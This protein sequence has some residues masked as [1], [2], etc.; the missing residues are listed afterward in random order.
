VSGF[1]EFQYLSIYEPIDR[2]T[3]TRKSGKMGD[4][5]DDKGSPAVM[6]RTPRMLHESSFA[7][8]AFTSSRSQRR[9]P[10]FIASSLD[11]KFSA[12][13]ATV[14]P[15]AVTT[16]PGRNKKNNDKQQ[17][18]QLEREKQY[19][20]QRQYRSG[21]PTR[22][23]GNFGPPPHSVK[24]L[25]DLENMSEEQIYKLFMDDPDLHQEFIKATEKGG[26]NENTVPSTMPT[27]AKKARRSA[28][29]PSN[30]SKSKRSSTKPKNL[31]S[32]DVDREVPYFQW[33]FLFILIC[34]A[35]YKIYK[36]CSIPSSTKASKKVVGRKQKKKKVEKLGNKISTKTIVVEVKVKPNLPLDDKKGA[37]K[38]LSSK[39]KRR[40]KAPKARPT[41]SASAIVEEKEND[42]AQM[43]DQHHELDMDSED[44]S[45]GNHGSQT[46]KVD[47]VFQMEAALASSPSTN[48]SDEAWQTVTK[49]SKG[50]TKSKTTI[51]PSLIKETNVLDQPIAESMGDWDVVS[52]PKKEV[53]ENVGEQ[54]VEQSVKPSAEPP[55]EPPVEPSVEEPE[56]I[57]KK[58]K[59][60]KKKTGNDNSTNE[61]KKN[62]VVK[63]IET[64]KSEAGHA[65]EANVIVSEVKHLEKPDID[66]TEKSETTTVDDA[67]LALQLHEKEVNFAMST[68]GNPQEEVWEEVT[69]K[70]KA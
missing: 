14:A 56:F 42:P 26:Y 55:V 10:G 52:E 19:Q 13:G 69:K 53:V 3:I 20:Q 61:E 49:S 65:V 4:Q 33:L 16:K 54:S 45:S 64:M 18:E 58:K 70:K 32:K 11:F 44:G 25:E 6:K 23:Q 46:A 57:V 40:K 47:L 8:T 38:V 35:M 43:R 21:H 50:G 39:K 15:N 41:S 51:D 29:K 59:T 48:E 17:Q 62:I 22:A 68:G 7:T 67:A 5:H 66:S 36:A 30:S 9:A 31:K 2:T 1:F 28:R 24:S 63:P 34:A 37:E 60:K 27:G 12:T